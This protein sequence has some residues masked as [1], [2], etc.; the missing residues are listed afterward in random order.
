MRV[1]FVCKANAG[2]SQ[3]AEAFLRKGNGNFEVRSAGTLHADLGELVGENRYTGN[4]IRCMD[5]H[6]IDIRKKVR[7]GLTREMVGEADIIVSMVPEGSLP[8]YIDRKRLVLWDV[9]DPKG[10]SLEDTEKVVRKIK[11]LVDGLARQLA[12]E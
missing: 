8:E 6:G 4:V 11:R 12:K 9:E 2:R 5:R 7:K 10:M 1:L 3:V